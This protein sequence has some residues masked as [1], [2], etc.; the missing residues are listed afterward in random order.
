MKKALIFFL[1]PLI[2]VEVG[3]YMI[4]PAGGTF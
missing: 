4:L 2:A 1:L 3:V